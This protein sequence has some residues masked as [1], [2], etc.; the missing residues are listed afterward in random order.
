MSACK[1]EFLG[2]AK[3][4]PLKRYLNIT[5]QQCL[6]STSTI[7]LNSTYQKLLGVLGPAQVRGLSKS[8]RHTSKCGHVLLTFVTS[9]AK[10]E[11][12]VWVGFALKSTCEIERSAYHREKS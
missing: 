10:L 9:Y 8:V 6:K 4:G 11:M 5:P 3:F 7:P 12:R 1:R 2:G